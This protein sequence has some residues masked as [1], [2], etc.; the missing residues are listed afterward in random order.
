MSL[1]VTVELQGG[2]GNRLFQLA[3]AAWYAQRHKRRLVFFEETNVKS[4]LD[5]QSTEE[6][7]SIAGLQTEPMPGNVHFTYVK[8]TYEDLN[9]SND[10]ACVCLQGQFQDSRFAD[11]LKGL[12]EKFINS[13]EEPR[14]QN[15]FL[16]LRNSVHD[17]YYTKSLRD[18]VTQ[19]TAMGAMSFALGT[20]VDPQV[21]VYSTS[22]RAV[23]EA[24]VSRLGAKSW[25]LMPRMSHVETLKSMMSCG[26]A[27]L[28]NSAFAWWA[29][30]FMQWSYSDAIIFLP[31][32]WERVPLFSRM[33]SKFT[34][35]RRPLAQT[36]W[37]EQEMDM[38]P[39]QMT[40]HIVAAC[41]MASI[42]M[43]TIF[44]SIKK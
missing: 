15:T 11:G 5:A 1:L 18:L 38:G 36:T 30:Q 10:A 31:Q 41:L 12:V 42:V 26:S 35:R 24:H 16:H 25:K 8:G 22:S 23:V 21:E 33:T 43:R 27:I 29:A 44:G 9:V 3:G 20:R 19:R 17:D 7:L 39:T 37:I 14:R 13:V 34:S 28:S 40:L 32:Q 4:T 6:L 2:F